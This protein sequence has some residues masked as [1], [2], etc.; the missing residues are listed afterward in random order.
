M[1][2]VALLVVM[3]VCIV[4]IYAERKTT[5]NTDKIEEFQNTLLY[6]YPESYKKDSTI[7]LIT[8]YIA[9]ETVYALHVKSSNT[10]EQRV[11]TIHAEI[12][13][14]VCE[15]LQ[16]N[17]AENVS[18]SKSRDIF[19]VSWTKPLYVPNIEPYIEAPAMMNALLKKYE[20]WERELCE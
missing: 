19:L 2:R 1:I 13:R 17:H 4:I 9:D 14:E 10:Y 5:K 7:D 20:Q 16:K 12:F 6:S 15:Q 11:G 18:L 3:A 8:V